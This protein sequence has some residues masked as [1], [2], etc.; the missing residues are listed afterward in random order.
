MHWLELTHNPLAIKHLYDSVPPLEAMESI[1]MHIN[2]EGPKLK[3]RM[4]FPRFADHRPARWNKNDN[5]VHIELDFWTIS[6]L[7]I[8]GFTTNPIL[9]FSTDQVDHQILVRAEGQGIRIR[10]HCDTIY[11]Q[12]VSGYMN[13]ERPPIERS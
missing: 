9:N 4:N 6:N 10:F 8:D 12:K 7:E 1:D 5:T 3:L 13:T 2:R 11:I